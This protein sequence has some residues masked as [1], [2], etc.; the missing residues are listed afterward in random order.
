M[1]TIDLNCDLGEGAGHDDELMPL[2][3]SANIAC[4]GHAGNEETM[5]EAIALAL[6]HGVSI[7]AHPGVADRAGFGR[8]D[9]KLSAQGAFALVRDQVRALARLAAECGARVRHVK[10][11]GALYN[12]AARRTEIADAIALAV[13]DADPGLILVGLAGG[14]LPAAGQRRGLRV[15]SE[16]FADRAY[17][18][19]GSLTPRSRPGALIVDESA[20]TAQALRIV[21]E[22]RVRCL[23]GSDIVVSA[24]TL[25]LHGDGPR[26]VALAR[27][28]RKEFEAA[29][30]ELRSLA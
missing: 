18:P 26:A 3:T 4:G 22:G 27:R 28:M 15:A 11:H 10:P 24:S 8:T 21:R 2:V 30:V 17:Q 25:C 16:A 14:C 23:D 19:D 9:S 20:A 5:R 1:P 12:L 6:R 7:G 29:G 13:R